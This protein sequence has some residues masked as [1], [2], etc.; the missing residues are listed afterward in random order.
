MI[1]V[2]F[3]FRQ[4][5]QRLQEQQKGRSNIE[6]FVINSQGEMIAS[7]DPNEHSPI[8]IKGQDQPQLQLLKNSKNPYFQMAVKILEE[9]AID[10][11]LFSS[12]QQWISKNPQ[13]GKYYY[14]SLTRAVTPMNQ[15][16]WFIGT[17]IPEDQYMG[18]IKKIIRFYWG[19]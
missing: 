6:V 16:H 14:V 12:P 15:L 2:G 8:Q 18:T 19:L 4:I 13:N 11:K 1:G 17:V 9:R 5:S 10:L 3:E 7:T